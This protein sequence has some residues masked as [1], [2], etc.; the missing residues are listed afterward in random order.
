MKEFWNERYADADYVYGKAPNEYFKEKIDEM[1]PGKIL[2]PAEGEGRNA[3]Y[4][5]VLEWEVSA[6]DISIKGKEKALKLAQ[7]E[8][9]E[10]D[11][12]VGGLPQLDYK[13]E[14]FDCIALIFAHFS[15]DKKDNYLKRFKQL[16]KGGG[17]IIFEAFSKE[18]IDIQKDNPK[19][20]GP[21][22][23]EMLFSKEELQTCFSGYEFEEFEDL[24][25]ELSEG[26]FHQGK[27]AVIRF[28]ARKP[29]N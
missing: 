25:T 15:E 20:G 17:V 18:Q 10:I 23:A 8:N 9:V 2:L 5:A 29:L 4:A 6:F 12:K 14:Q 1:Q 28:V 21:K 11:Y 19:S 3:V 27:A 26:K 24:I 7:T 13:E 22:N 16:L